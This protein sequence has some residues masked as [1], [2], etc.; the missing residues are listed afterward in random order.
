VLSPRKASARPAYANAPMFVAWP[1]SRVPDDPINVLV[2]QYM[3]VSS[4]GRII[5][6]C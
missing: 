6:A 5:A 4:L 1:R 3:P 2:R